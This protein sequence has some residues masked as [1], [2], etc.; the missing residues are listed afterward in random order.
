MFPNRKYRLFPRLKQNLRCITILKYYSNRVIA[1][2]KNDS[3]GEQYPATSDNSVVRYADAGSASPTLIN[4]W[5]NPKRTAL[6][7][8]RLLRT[9]G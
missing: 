6:T 7:R 4:A 9:K 5:G 1:L 2:I 3:K 8:H